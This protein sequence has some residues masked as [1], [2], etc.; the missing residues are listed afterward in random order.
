[1]DKFK[2]LANGKKAYFWKEMSK[3]LR[4]I[5][6]RIARRKLKAELKKKL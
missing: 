4:V 2:K 3:S 1:M 5:R 6:M